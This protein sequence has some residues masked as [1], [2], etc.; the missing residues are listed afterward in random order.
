M[1]ALRHSIAALT[2]VAAAPLVAGA[3]A[4]RPAWRVGLRERLGALPRDANG[5]IWI[6]AASIGE[7]LSASSLE[8]IQERGDVGI[9]LADRKILARALLVAVPREP[10]R[11]VL[12]DG[13][14]AP[15]W[16]QGGPPPA[17]L[18]TRLFRVESRSVP[19]GM[20]RRV[21]VADRVAGSGAHWLARTLEP[22]GVESIVVRGPGAAELSAE[23][24][25]G[26]IAPFTGSSILPSDPGPLPLWD[27]GAS[28]LRFSGSP[29]SAW[30]QQKP[31]VLLI[32]PEA[33]PGLGFEGELL[34]ARHIARGLSRR[35]GPPRRIP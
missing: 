27:L 31:P 15:E 25:L 29:V 5:S 8:L 13:E 16:L 10:L 18:P 3:L 6:H 17:E 20:A 21:I 26:A 24:P 28:E 32:G 1:G 9:A 19:V 30:L 11:R 12:E 35:L 22:D 7:I 23:D 14:G 33:A 2:A 34:G 4:V